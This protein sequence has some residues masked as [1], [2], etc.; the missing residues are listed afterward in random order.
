M[1]KKKAN[2]SF[3]SDV[4]KQENNKN[5]SGIGNIYYYK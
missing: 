3:I 4:E 2:H 5:Y 1:S